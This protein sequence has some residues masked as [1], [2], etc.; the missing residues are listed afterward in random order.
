MKLKSPSVPPVSRER[1]EKAL[2]TLVPREEWVLRCRWG[3]DKDLPMSLEAIANKFGV[4]RERI[5]QIQN[6]ALRKLHHPSRGIWKSD[7]GIYD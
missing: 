2:L 4:S 3:L 6:K 5:R 1:L 7:G